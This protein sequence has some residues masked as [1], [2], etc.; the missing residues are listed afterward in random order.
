MRAD[1]Q[2]HEKTVTVGQR[3]QIVTRLYF[4]ELSMLAPSLE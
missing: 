2:K 4:R 3:R 1:V